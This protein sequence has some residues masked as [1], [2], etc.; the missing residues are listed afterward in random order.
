MEKLSDS[1]I[2]PFVLGGAIAFCLDPIADALERLLRA[3]DLAARM[4]E[5]GRRRVEER[6]SVRLQVDRLLTLWTELCESNA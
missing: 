4:G 6:F 1:E 5:A 2:L 3:P